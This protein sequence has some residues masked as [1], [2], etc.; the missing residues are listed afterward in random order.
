MHQLNSLILS[1]GQW[2]VYIPYS[3]IIQLYLYIH[4]QKII[5]RLDLSC[6]RLYPCSLLLFLSF[7][8]LLREIMDYYSFVR[9]AIGIA[10]I[11][12]T[13]TRFI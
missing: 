1:S 9:S 6:I 2:P 7:N 5:F 12:D 10:M 13:P 11:G 8:L 3:T 4:M